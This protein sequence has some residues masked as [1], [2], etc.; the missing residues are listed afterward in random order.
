MTHVEDDVTEKKHLG[1]VYFCTYRTFA[2]RRRHMAAILYL[3]RANEEGKA[4][5]GGIYAIFHGGS[6]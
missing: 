4:D 1:S 6:A 2:W 5:R 3:L